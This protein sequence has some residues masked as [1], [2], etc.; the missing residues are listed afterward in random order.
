MDKFVTSITQVESS[1]ESLLYCVRTYE[2]WYGDRCRY[3][4]R[5]VGAGRRIDKLVARCGLVCGW[6]L[7]KK[8]GCR[9]FVTTRRLYF[10]LRAIRHLVPNKLQ[11]ALAQHYFGRPNPGGDHLIRRILPAADPQRTEL[12]NPSVGRQAERGL[13]YIVGWVGKSGSETSEVCGPACAHLYLHLVLL[14]LMLHV[15]QSLPQLINELLQFVPGF[16]K[17]LQSRAKRNC[18]N[19]TAVALAFKMHCAYG[20]LHEPTH[21]AKS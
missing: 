12:Y 18:Q 8:C 17:F 7:A 6:V 4:G 10:A 15:G 16:T 9:L 20:T 11:M 19:D 13:G 5:Y 14:Q 21:D 1:F 2:C 3:R